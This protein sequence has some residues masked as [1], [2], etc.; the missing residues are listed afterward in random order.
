MSRIHLWLAGILILGLVACAPAPSPEPTATPPATMTPTLAPAPSPTPTVGAVPQ[1]TGAEAAEEAQIRIVNAAPESSAVDVYL[2]Q[3]LIASRLGFGAHTNPV[4]VTTASYYLHVVPVNALPDSQ[5]LADT[6]LAMEPDQSY[7]VVITGTAET[8]VVSVY[9]EDLS[10]L[11]DNSSRIAFLNAVPRGPNLT[12]QIDTQPFADLLDF[13]QVS[14]GYI[15]E[16]GARQ[17]VFL[18]GE[19]RLSELD[20]AL[21]PQQAY[22]AILIGKP[23]AEDTRILLLNTPIVGNGQLRFIH[24]APETEPLAVLV[25]GSTLAES[26]EYRSA[27][28]WQPLKPQTYTLELRSSTDDATLVAETRISLTSNQAAEVVLLEDHGRPTLRVYAYSLAPT[29]SDTARIVIVNAAPYAPTVYGQTRAARLDEFP[30]VPGGANS[31]MVEISANQLELLW[32]SGQGDSTR[33]IEWAGEVTFEEGILYTYIITGI[34][35]DPFLLA[36]DV[37][38]EAMSQATSSLDT[39]HSEEIEQNQSIRIIHALA[40][41]IPLRVRLGKDTVLFRLEPQTVSP[42]Y[43]VD[44]EATT[45]RIGP[46][47]ESSN[48]PDYLITTLPS[49]ETPT[50]VLLYAHAEHMAHSLIPDS[51]VLDEA[52]SAV[53]R[54][55]N[56]ITEE[57]AL[58]IHYVPATLD[59]TDS[60]IQAAS[61]DPAHDQQIATLQ[62]GEATDFVQLLPGTYDVVAARAADN[63]ILA[64]IPALVVEARTLQEIILL[65]EPDS[66]GYAMILQRT[67][68]EDA[69]N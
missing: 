35:R 53:M 31:P 24:A 23:G 42:R 14:A 25:N 52:D 16:S 58:V 56:A 4:I 40:D 28:D 30:Q 1:R 12:P 33:V 34:D 65:Q 54:L 36:T 45:L 69:P 37:G 59:N 51:P 2:E 49:I 50:S 41:P 61:P 29:P 32:V 38:V 9:Q 43:N 21:A 60:P 64:I 67:S 62:P 47:D 18:A 17:L 66:A 63:T 7:I 39:P 6:T 57:D 55:Y 8:L 5:V 20:T 11:P 13:G 26:I 68:L 22:T 19:Q 3:G 46:A 48:H 44:A 10:I 15:V 27:S